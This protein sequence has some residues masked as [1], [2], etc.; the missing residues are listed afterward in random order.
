MVNLLITGKAVSNT[1][2]NIME[3]DT[4][5][6]EKVALIGKIILKQSKLRFT[7][8][9]DVLLRATLQTSAATL[10]FDGQFAQSNCNRRQQPVRRRLDILSRLHN[11]TLTSILNEK[12][13]SKNDNNNNNNNNNNKIN[14]LKSQ[15]VSLEPGSHHRRLY[16]PAKNCTF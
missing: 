12:K 4:G 1:F 15:H 14:T 13:E 5:G 10:V 6:A 9:P 11:V 3:V 8:R 2:D 7:V 16:V